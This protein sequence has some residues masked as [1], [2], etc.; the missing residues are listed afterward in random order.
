MNDTHARDQEARRLEGKETHPAKKVP[1][2]QELLDESLDQTFPASDPISPS[3]AMHAD[4][5][6]STGKDDTD[7]TL[8]PGQCAPA[9]PDPAA[10]KASATGGEPS[11]I[12]MEAES[13]AGEEDP[14][15]AVE[16]PGR[17]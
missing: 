6:V 14:G 13:A 17:G 8:K 10:K 12:D 5:Q 3:A 2:Y 9:K 11:G 7:W 4:R 1:T 15:A 16:S